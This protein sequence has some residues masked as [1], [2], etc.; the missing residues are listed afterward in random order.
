MREKYRGWRVLGERFCFWP[1]E[2]L[3]GKPESERDGREK[4]SRE[5]GWSGRVEGTREARKKR[6]SGVFLLFSAREEFYQVQVW[7]ISSS[8][9][10]II[11]SFQVFFCWFN[12]HPLFGNAY[13][14]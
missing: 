7:S 12:F 5:F 14:C 4:Q 13:P 6:N 9:F 8:Y 11:S 1:L 10:L 3:L 2:I